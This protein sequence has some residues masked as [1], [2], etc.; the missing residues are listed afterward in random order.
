MRE[1]ILH[2][3][4][5]SQWHA[6]LNEAQTQVHQTL[7]ID[8]ESYLVFMLMRFITQNQLLSS[9]LALEFLETLQQNGAISRSVRLDH[10]QTIG[11]KSLL[12]CS[13][14]PGMAQKRHV[15]LH[16]FAEMGQQAYWLLSRQ[17]DTPNAALFAHLSKQF[18][19]LQRI[20]QA[21]KN[22]DLS[23][24][25]LFSLVDFTRSSPH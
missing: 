11:D 21:L 4:D 8:I 18:Q 17:V 5:L 2:P 14:F 7:P 24:T 25:M 22:P 9:I 23:G 15:S 6:L 3:T 20:L 10:L 16:Y 19:T 1:L 12:F 13:L